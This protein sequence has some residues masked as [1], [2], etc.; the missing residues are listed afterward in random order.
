MKPTEYDQV[1]KDI[2][3]GMHNGYYERALQLLADFKMHPAENEFDTDY[4]KIRCFLK[5]GKYETAKSLIRKNLNRGN[6]FEFNR[7]FFDP[8]RN[9]EEF[10]IFESINNSLIS[11][12]RKKHRPMSKV[13]L[14]EEYG[15]NLAYPMIIILHGDGINGNAEKIS[16]LW[17]PDL[18]LEMGYIVAYFQSPFPSC[19]NYFGWYDDLPGSCDCIKI[20]YYDMLEDYLI[21]EQRV[22]IFGY[23]GGAA[24]ALYTAAKTSIKFRGVVLQSLPEIG[25]PIFNSV[26]IG[27]IK[28]TVFFLLEGELS[29]DENFEYQQKITDLLDSNGIKN[30]YAIN[31]N[32]G[33]EIPEDIVGKT[34]D[35]QLLGLK[36]CNQSL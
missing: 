25:L 27:K 26:E 7:D 1:R 28:K 21:D 10:E 5:L 17:V 13:F 22:F 18:Y 4:I 3:H 15:K 31:E 23:S 20:L 29:G 35:S 16:E 9:N 6:F 24:A 14:P 2:I 34:L 8:I 33:D 12:E 11:S 32:S 19:K 36:D 30:Q